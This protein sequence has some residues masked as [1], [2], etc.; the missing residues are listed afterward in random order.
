V[1]HPESPGFPQSNKPG[2]EATGLA[3]KN[4]QLPEI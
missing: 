4:T 2:A 3:V 1:I